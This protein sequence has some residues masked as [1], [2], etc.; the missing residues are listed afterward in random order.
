[1]GQGAIEPTRVQRCHGE[2]E[3]DRKADVTEIEQGRVND[4]TDILQH[5][6]EIAPLQWP[7][8]L[9]VKRAGEDQCI[10]AEQP[11][12]QPHD[13]QYSSCDQRIDPLGAKGHQRAP[14][15]QRKNEKEHGAL[16]A[17]PHR[18][19]FEAKRQGAVGVVGHIADSEIIL[20]KAAGEQQ[21]GGQQ[22]DGIDQHQLRCAAQQSW[23]G[24]P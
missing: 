16:M 7:R 18:R 1:M 20:G 9:A 13:G 17:A 4:K 3:V 6:V 2:G 10:E 15:P 11:D 19:Q 24:E 23:G 8:E 12:D 14:Q 21:Q 22:Q 5:G